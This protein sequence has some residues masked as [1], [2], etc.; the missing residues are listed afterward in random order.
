MGYLKPQ[1]RGWLPWPQTPTRSL[2][3]K[4]SHERMLSR[5]KPVFS[6]EGG[7]SKGSAR[8]AAPGGCGPGRTQGAESGPERPAPS[9][10]RG[11]RPAFVRGPAT[12]FQG[13]RRQGPRWRRPA[14]HSPEEAVPALRLVGEPGENVH[15]AQP[16]PTRR[17]GLVASRRVLPG[18]RGSARLRPPQGLSLF[19]SRGRAH[20]P[21]GLSRLP[22]GAGSGGY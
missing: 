20:L 18:S 2:S 15:G 3:L 6:G 17:P 11:V 9:R 4:S 8:P 5:G 19:A 7:S 16:R 13:C 10:G 1:P 22:V 21:R 12:S 14:A